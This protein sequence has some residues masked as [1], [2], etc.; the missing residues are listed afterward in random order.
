MFASV[1]KEKN[2][3]IIKYEMKMVR[4]NFISG[5]YSNCFYSLVYKLKQIRY[6]AVKRL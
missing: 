3:L 1:D 6:N 5:V 2:Q 4:M